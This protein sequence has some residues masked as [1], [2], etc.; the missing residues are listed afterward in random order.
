M[1]AFTVCEVR[2]ALPLRL[3]FSR[4]QTARGHNARYYALSRT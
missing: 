4:K 2:L 1:I 3:L